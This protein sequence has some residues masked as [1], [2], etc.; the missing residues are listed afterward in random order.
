MM[1]Q[2]SNWNGVVK[3]TLSQSLY[4]TGSIL[5]MTLSGIVG[6]LL[7][8]D[9]SLATLPI[10]L[11]SVGTACTMIPASLLIRK[12]GQKTGFMV[13]A[14]FGLLAGL[15]TALG[16]LQ[17]SFALFVVG[18]MFIGCWQGFTQYYRFAA[19]DAVT[20]EDKGKAISFVMI[21]G[22]VAAIAGPNLA[23]YTQGLG[24][25][26]FL[27]SYLSLMALS[28][29]SI[30]VL[31]SLRLRSAVSVRAVSLSEPRPL[32]AIISQGSI[33]TAFTASAVG[34]SVMIMIMTAT[35]LAMQGCGHS[36]GDS[37]TV[38]QWHVLGMFV[39]SFFTGALIKRFGAHNVI[40]AGIGILFLHVALALAGTDFLHFI[41]GLIFL[42]IGWNFMF[43][44]G[45]TLL[46]QAYRIE[47]KEKTQ[48]L[49]DF[50]VFGIISISSFLAGSIL[51]RWGWSAVNISVIPLLLLALI[52][53]VFS[54]GAARRRIAGLQNP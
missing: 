18:N 54:K 15:L 49:H 22:V 28:V 27:M 17:H 43:I 52:T 36:S 46:T 8:S 19:A 32:S 30:A 9:K 20:A 41:S 34:Y 42:G 25:T 21:G 53:M 16:V 2:A 10:A 13:G 40:I 26:P 35:P 31:S 50:L 51:N 47:E 4:Q 23:K 11:I 1:T 33:L 29:L 7:A 5:V 24:T 14:S 12:Y 6:Q 45:T 3:L 38:I 48:A 44:G 39:P 37:A